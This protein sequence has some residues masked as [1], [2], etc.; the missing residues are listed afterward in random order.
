MSNSHFSR[1]KLFYRDSKPKK[2]IMQKVL[3]FE[4]ASLFWNC[5]KLYYNPLRGLHVW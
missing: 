2:N 3:S 1:N 5:F 4:V